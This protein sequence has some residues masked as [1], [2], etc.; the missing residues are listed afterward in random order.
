MRPATLR[1]SSELL[2]Q[3]LYSQ[4]QQQQQQQDEEVG[5]RNVVLDISIHPSA[6]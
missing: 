6:L 5:R 4:Q 2:T 3:Y 1:G